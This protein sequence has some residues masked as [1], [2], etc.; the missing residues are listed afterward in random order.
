[1]DFEKITIN[2]F[3]RKIVRLKF[4]VFGD[5]VMLYCDDRL[6]ALYQLKG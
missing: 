3:F 5:M 1:M 6:E 2:F 4:F